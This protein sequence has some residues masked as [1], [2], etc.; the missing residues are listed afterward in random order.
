[1]H[2]FTKIDA[3]VTGKDRTYCEVLNCDWH[4]CVCAYV[5]A[6]GGGAFQIVHLTCWPDIYHPAIQAHVTR[7]VHIVDTGDEN[8]V[9]F[10]RLFCRQSVRELPWA[11]CIRAASV[12]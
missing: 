9:L 8:V 5:G 10:M 4:A 2:T 6:C 12:A 3:Q 1:M 11:T 7:V